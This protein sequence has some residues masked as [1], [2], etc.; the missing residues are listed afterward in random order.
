MIGRVVE[1]PADADVSMPLA[2]IGLAARFSQEA[3][4]PEAFWEF[5]LRARQSTTSFPPD[6]LNQNAFYHPDPD[7]GG[8]VHAKGAHFLQ[9]NPNAFDA[10]FFNINKTEI[11]S[12]DPQQRL[13]MEN[14]YHALENAG[15]PMEKAI[16][17]NASMFASGFN[18]DHSNRMNSDLETSMKHRS[19]GS[20]NSMISGRVSWFYDFRGPSMTVDTAC[21]S[22]MVAFHLACQ[23]LKSGDSETAIVSG[24]NAISY[25]PHILGM[26]YSGFLG[27]EGKCFTF[28]NRG[29]GY[30]RGEGV[31]TVI[32]K[33]LVSALKDGD[34]IRAVIRAT[35]LN[36]DGRTP[37]MTYP[38]GDAQVRLIRS[39]YASAGLDPKDTLFSEAHGTGTPAGD[40]IEARSIARAFQCENRDMP[41]YIGAV[42]SGIG[43]LEGGSGV[44][45]IIKAILMLESAII[46]PNVNFENVNPKI[47]MEKWNLRFPTKCLPWPVPDGARRASV[48]CF[49]L[50]GT[51]AHCIL[52]DAY[53]YLEERGLVGFHNSR[54]SAPTPEEVD[55]IVTKTIKRY[56]AME[57][58]EL[59]AAQP[60]C[61]ANGSLVNGT[62]AEKP[63]PKIFL[64]SAFD[65]NGLKRLATGINSYL[66][67]QESWSGKLSSNMYRDLAYTLSEKRSRFRW[68][69][70]ILATSI[71]DLQR[72]LSS[73]MVLSKASNV[74]VAPK[75][76]FVFTGQGAQYSQMGHQLLGYPVF[77]KSLE[78]AS[79]F[80]K[81][82]GSPWSL[83]DEISKQKSDSRIDEPVLS[84][85][86]LTAIQVALVQ[87]LASWNISPS[88][89]IGHSSGEI[90]A[91]Y[92]AGKISREAAWT[93]AYY[94]GSVAAVMPTKVKGAML[95]VGLEATKLQ[96]YLDKV[97]SEYTGEL[98]IA[99]F[100]SPKNNTV[101]G[102]EV[103]VDALKE[104]L[105]AD[106]IFARK[107]RT[108]RAYHSAHMQGSA[109]DYLK[110]LSAPIYRESF[111]GIDS[112]RMFS[113]SRGEEVLESSLDGWYWVHNLVSTVKFTSV[114]LSMCLE[115]G[116]PAV[117]QIVE[118]GPHG[119]LQS[120][121]KET[122]GADS[123]ISYLPTLVR[124]DPGPN[125]LLESVG[126]LAAKGV[127][128]NIFE[129]NEAAEPP[130]SLRPQM[131]VSLPPYPFNHEEAGIFESRLSKNARFRE[132]PRHDLFGAPV[133]D[134]N[135][136]NPK[137][138]HFLRTSENPW[139]KDHVI[140]GNIVF[141]GA[142]FMVMAIEASRQLVQDN[143]VTG[144][145]LRDIALKA[146]LIVP[147]T[148]DGVETSL[149]L[150]PMDD[151]NISTSNVWNKFQINSYD[152]DNDEWVE[153]C[154]GYI[155]VDMASHPN[156]V[157][158]GRE[159]TLEKEK[160]EKAFH[161]A[162]SACKSPLD[163]SKVYDDLEHLG[164]EFGPLFRNLSAVTTT[165]QKGGSALA[166][167]TVPD[168]R[169]KMPK[170]YIHSHLI[171][172]ATLDSVFQA[173]M[174]SVCGFTG[175][176]MLKRGLVP[177]FIKSAWVS[178]ET[179]S[180]SSFRCA[181]KAS[182]STFDIYNVDA[183]VWGKNGNAPNIAIQGVR[184]TPFQSESTPGN[185]SGQL[186]YSIDWK[187][188]VHFLDTS[189]FRTL[190]PF[191][192]NAGNYEAEKRWFS[193]LQLAAALLVTDALVE[194]QGI[195]VA[196]LETHYQ[197]FYDLLKHVTADIMT[198]CIPHVT[199]NDWQKYSQN[200]QLKQDLYKEV[201]SYDTNGAVLLRMGSQIASIFKNLADPLFLMFGQDD[202]MTRY[203]DDDVLMGP[204]PTTLDCYLSLLRY[205]SSG[206]KVLEVGAGTGGFTK[207]LL[208]SLCPR[209]E[210]TAVNQS[211]VSGDKIASY[212]F[213]DISP[214]FFEKA[215]DRLSAWGDILDFQKLDAGGD[216]E[217]QGFQP[218]SYDMVFASNVLHA[219]PDIHQTLQNVRSLLKPGGKLLFLEGVRQD[220]LW[221]NV[222]FSG[223]PGWWLGKEPVRRWCPYVSTQEW[224]GF[225][226][227]SGFSGIDIDMPSSQYPEFTKISI[228]A[229]TAVQTIPDN[230]SQEFVIVCQYLD[231]PV[232]L[233]QVLK[234]QLE[235]ALGGIKCSLIFPV[236]LPTMDLSQA[237]C[238]SLLEVEAP[239]LGKITEDMFLNIRHMLTTCARLL[240]VTGD[241]AKDPG[242]NIA[243]GLIRTIRWERDS[244]EL[245]LTTL[246]ANLGATSTEDLIQSILKITRH[247]FVGEMSSH[248]NSE[249]QLRDGLIHTNRIVENS[250]ATD[251]ITA[252]FSTPPAQLVPW[253]SIDRPVMIQNSQPGVLDKL[254]WST[255]PDYVQDLGEFEVEID[256]KA[257]GLN[258][259]DLLTAMGELP[260]TT[261]GGE[262]AG[263]VSSIGSKVTRFNIGDRVAYFA[264]PARV[265]TFRTYG[266]ANQALVVRIP[267]HL[268]LSLE[269]AAGLPVIY[270][271]VI[272]ALNNIG[273]LMAREKVLIHAAAGGVGQAAIQ[274]A[275]A[276]GAEIFATVSSIE[277]RDFLIQE[278]GLAEDHIFSSRDLTFAK[279]VMR[280]TED[281]G[282]DVILNSLSGEALQQSWA[283]IGAFG[284]FIELGKRDIQSGGKLDMT[285]FLKNATMAG[286]D[287]LTVAQLRPSV[288]QKLLDEMIRLWAHGKIHEARPTTVLPYGDLEKG[289]RM[290]QAGTTFGKLVFVPG[291]EPVPVVPALATRYTFDSNASYVLA[292]GLGGIARSIAQW[293]ASRGAKH[294]ILLCR[295]ISEAALKM[296][297]QLGK[298]G[299]QAYVIQC[300]ITDPDRL[301][302]VITECEE[303]LPPIKGCINCS[304][305]WADG[306]FETM[307]HESWQKSL[308]PKMNG[309][310]NL[311]EV[312]P[313]E[314]DF[315]VMLASVAGVV[316]N[317]SQANYNAG[318]TFEDALARYRVSQG[319]RATS[320][321]LGAVLSVGFMAENKEFVRHSMKIANH[322][323]EHEMLAII[324]YLVDPR[325]ALTET[326]CQLVC[327]LAT[328]SAYQKRR[329]PP[330]RHLEYPMFMHLQGTAASGGAHSEDSGPIYNVP[331]LLAAAR[332][333]EEGANIVLT[334][335]QRKLT[336]LLNIQ[337][338][339]L[340]QEKSIRH[341][342]VD[343]LIE[344][345]FR[346]WLG[347]ELG[348]SVSLS[349]L[350]TKSI[351]DLSL[352]VATSSTYSHFDAA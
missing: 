130:R 115:G 325:Q 55:Q 40:P 78:D 110:A 237:V 128:V 316:G 219:T 116:A 173:G 313:K 197:R 109:Q 228:M 16:S 344:M 326:T 100:N 137:W 86:C 180:E 125:T 5:L 293:M 95:A 12:L 146:M 36:Q 227:R 200:E 209:S 224:D 254:Q 182:L 216:P 187:P 58:G 124:Q 123:S 134:W 334:G 202:L 139:L 233:A 192:P 176:S 76:G 311:H 53:H 249:Y 136:Q 156:P 23:S 118:I 221:S 342:G 68:N 162:T 214:R 297:R 299:C 135:P 177:N 179:G 234:N 280:M 167:I 251:A 94:R 168:I 111:A 70:C 235:E 98:I 18:H 242:F 286:V 74:R 294:L 157:D 148:Q 204:I 203:Y 269:I 22:S 208:D 329:I 2:V 238:I 201:E 263:I 273:R 253:S 69:N 170:Q 80:I 282:V 87:L 205:N 7:H 6:R 283:C 241:P 158:N 239:M 51:N 73:G 181:G 101:S 257:V 29:D 222:S 175:Q 41:M 21:S 287:L 171:H 83:I 164:I 50:S 346:T 93:D 63:A 37:G 155:A 59:G 340:D 245:N 114:L 196:S 147:E 267:D 351:T 314:L 127:P 159:E 268:E 165:G 26:S 255:D 34:T 77:R 300:D 250:D 212:A 24:V 225:L 108:G 259:R 64:L 315:F 96:P 217:S 261:I 348:A 199:F 328:Q 133:Q 336:S 198:G 126:A 193:R 352:K 296:T 320:A 31:A 17:S 3:T 106:N 310:L 169:S 247:Q 343:S 166:T 337:E 288:I 271:T 185:G 33:P 28:D 191:D 89:V 302:E 27:A 99:C 81:Q 82:L 319:Q 332:S 303:T 301:R 215:K 230:N 298:K 218:G 306:G 335:I 142:G 285:P 350:T 174:A 318:N 323:R 88:R 14:V 43:H 150:C 160:W 289:L 275:Q 9:E 220:T 52:D 256:V 262:A 194:I 15:I 195:S 13:V 91:A 163:F 103:M 236:D 72:K 49:G 349:D 35:S 122:I 71:D 45:A 252:Q 42:K 189:S 75:I 278:Y 30:A 152:V 121:I 138:R 312:L 246:A 210:S 272:Y 345:E 132:H 188:D 54:Q 276:I 317:R 44:A 67:R 144:F 274:Y 65:Q 213:T 178:A 56:Q 284:R 341:N 248:R 270:T 279:G 107:L 264:D 11:L 10:A 183:Q 145:R 295:T 327:G 149:S 62:T 84:H 32:L 207:R 39:A 231:K 117:Q 153:N 291:E 151:T 66:Q 113:S 131:L 304:V 226:R 143:T 46:P 190:V 339:Q 281:T 321:D 129:A 331:G 120:A 85:P 112:V 266:R 211:E 324:E 104:L 307:S 260:Q 48:S 60:E 154:T 347:K 19:T 47:E 305:A 57:E 229:S 172:P 186:C 97:H 1:Q 258:F 292:G 338:D 92:C 240:W 141:P 161:E 309:S 25:L 184:L 105:D 38:S 244:N 79:E 308:K 265:G 90:A 20:E 277:K 330:P 140:A 8:T 119:A 322:H 333:K 290:L 232:A 4:T 223:L 243:T 102:D 206:L 61:H